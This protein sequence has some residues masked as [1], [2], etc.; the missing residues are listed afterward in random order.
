MNSVIE[1]LLAHKSIRKFTEQKLTTEEIETLVRAAQSASTSS[2][3]QAYSIIGVTD[4]QI[5]KEL[6]EISTQSYVEHNGHLFIFVADYHRHALMSKIHDVD[7][8][9]YLGS[10]ESFLVGTID[11]ALAAQNMAVAAES[12][13][14]GICYIGSLR[15]DMQRVIE[16]LNLPEWT[17]PLFGMVV[18]HSADETATKKLRL[19]LHNV[20]HENHYNNDDESFIE[21]INDYDKDVSAYYK[22]RTNGERSDAWSEQI[23]T[24]LNKK[25]RQ[26]VDG[27]IK[28]QGFL[29][30]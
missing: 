26:H 3:V 20:Y 4:E 19:P 27:V 11:A 13:D 17:Y 25:S 18:G 2:Y 22:E 1:Q 30:Q 29:K 9:N 23:I 15:N 16:L 12:M 7:I 28:G 14:L 21:Q 8:N 6:R 5:K 10:T 24:F